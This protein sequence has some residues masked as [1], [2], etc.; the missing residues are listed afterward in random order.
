MTFARLLVQDRH[1]S[2][3]LGHRSRVHIKAEAEACFEFAVESALA[4]TN[5]IDFN[6]Y[7]P[8]SLQD[9]EK[10]MLTKAIS[11]SR[12]CSEP[13]LCSYVSD[14]S[15]QWTTAAHSLRRASS[16]LVSV[17][18]LWKVACVAKRL[19][20]QRII[21]IALISAQKLSTTNAERLK[22]N[23]SE[24]T[25]KDAPTAF[26]MEYE[27]SRDEIR[28]IWSRKYPPRMQVVPTMPS[29]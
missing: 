14:S 27:R 17:T 21:P 8:Y 15:R 5:E 28:S 7:G 16:S 23:N 12:T 24:T 6:I 26:R 11:L 13:S 25:R 1:P 2:E 22:S 18:L 9:N 3:L 29:H 4:T 20:R 10:R 19:R